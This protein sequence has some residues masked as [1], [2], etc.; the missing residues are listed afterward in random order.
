[1]RIKT[2]LNKSLLYELSCQQVKGEMCDSR[3]VGDDGSMMVHWAVLWAKGVWWAKLR[4][5]SDEITF[6]FPGVNMSQLVEFVDNLY[7]EDEGD[8]NI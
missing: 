2:C 5:E 4:G 3:L 1:M 7:A 6:I 8:G